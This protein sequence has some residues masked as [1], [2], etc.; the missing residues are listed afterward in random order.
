[1]NSSATSNKAPAQPRFTLPTEAT[2]PAPHS[3]QDSLVFRH[4][5]P[6]SLNSP[7]PHHTPSRTLANKDEWRWRTLDPALPHPHHPRNKHRRTM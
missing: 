4:L 7:C 6:P 2:P 1:M 5:P 3:H